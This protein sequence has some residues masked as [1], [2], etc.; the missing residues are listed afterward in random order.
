MSKLLLRDYQLLCEQSIQ[1]AWVR[2]FR[3]TLSIMGTGLGK[4]IVFIYL[5][6]QSLDLTKQRAMVLAPAHL[7]NQTY[8][9]MM[10]NVPEWENK[11]LANGYRTVPSVGIVMA[12]LSAPEARII[13]GSV[14]TLTDRVPTDYEPITLDDLNITHVGD[15]IFV[16]KAK[17][18][19]RNV[20]VSERIDQ[21]LEHGL[22]DLLIIDEC[23]HAVSKGANLLRNRIWEIDALVGRKKTRLVGFTATA[24]RADGIGLGNAFEAITFSRSMEW[25]QKNGYLAPSL[26]PIRVHAEIALE[27]MKILHVDNWTQMIVKAWAEQAQDRLTLAY[28]ASVQDAKELA[29]AFQ[30]AGYRFGFVDATSCLDADGNVQPKDYQSKLLQQAYLGEIQGISN[31][32]VLLE[33]VDIPPASCMIWARP[34]TENP[35]I[36]TQAFGRIL[37]LWEGSA[38]VPKKE[39]AMIL[40]CVSQNLA[41]LSG[42]TLAGYKYDERIKEYIKAEDEEITMTTIGEA[43]VDLRDEQKGE[44]MADGVIYSIGRTVSKSGS[45]WN[46]NEENDVLTLGVSKEDML[47]ITAPFYTMEADLNYKADSLDQTL[48]NLPTI[49]KIKKAADF[50][51]RYSLWHVQRER[52]VGEGP[53]FS[54]GNGLDELMDFVTV[55]ISEYEGIEA[56]Y[57]KGKRWLYA[58]VSANQAWKL[59]ELGVPTNPLWNQ[60]DASKAI[61]YAISYKYNVLPK[62]GEMLLD[63]GK[64]LDVG[65]LKYNKELL[66]AMATIYQRRKAS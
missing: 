7:I 13:V 2:G 64:Y 44:F 16:K 62:I 42:G 17:L 32:N 29:Q 18:S 53:V 4:T 43:P 34:V 11:V 19:R 1:A 60:G 50:F 26:K 35:V 38:G 10:E 49:R 52:L 24:Y 39:N 65:L 66:S 48:D 22:F 47:C 21:L 20:L 61:T 25:G 12:E 58:P 27:S 23:H 54:A 36:F 56:L 15:A 45:N 57:K 5:M 30:A 59:R 28:A 9:R 31:F 14:P 63:C 55:Y 41:I 40:D 51:G 46:H 37:R 6:K 33:G 8:L 3:S